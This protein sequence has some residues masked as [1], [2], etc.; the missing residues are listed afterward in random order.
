MSS[1][2][3]DIVQI[4][5]NVVKTPCSNLLP[6][7]LWLFP[8]RSH[9]HLQGQGGGGG[10]ARGE[11]GHYHLGVDGLLPLL[12]VHAQ[13]RHL[14]QGQVAGMMCYYYMCLFYNTV[15]EKYPRDKIKSL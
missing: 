15:S 6:A 13:H 14:R 2:N 7:V 9:Y 12:R 1:E 10:A 8:P 3:R 11:G 4:C 5:I